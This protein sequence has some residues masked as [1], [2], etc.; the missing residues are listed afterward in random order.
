V[1]KAEQT[2]WN[3]KPKTF[4]DKEFVAWIHKNMSCCLCGKREIEVHHIKDYEIVGRDDKFCLP[5]CVYHHRGSKFSVHGT[6][7][8]FRT[9]MPL[10]VQKSVAERLYRLYE[11]RKC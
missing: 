7:E 3:K 2:K 10:E 9:Y 5:L 6:P 8:Q 1:T 11:E 4:K